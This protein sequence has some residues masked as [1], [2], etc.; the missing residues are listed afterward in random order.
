MTCLVCEDYD[1]CIPCHVNVK[2]GHHPSHA[3]E[4]VSKVLAMDVRASALCA[5][6]RNMRHFAMCDGCDRVGTLHL[7]RTYHVN[8]LRTSTAFV[9]SA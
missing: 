5:P 7:P 6:G 1:L 4:P 8:K 9:T 2:H 3:F